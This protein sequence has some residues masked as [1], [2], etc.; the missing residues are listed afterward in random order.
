MKFA[1]AVNQQGFAKV[2][3]FGEAGSGKTFTAHAI[4]RGLHGYIKSTK[5]VVCVETESGVDF[6]LPLYKEAGIEIQVAKTRAFADLMGKNGLM[7]EAQKSADIMVIDSITHH[8]KDIVESYRIKN[9][10]TR[11]SFGDWNIIKPMWSVFVDLYL[12]SNLHIIECGRSGFEYDYF[13]NEDGKMELYKTGTKMKVEKEMAY[14]PSLMIEMERFKSFQVRKTKKGKGQAQS[15]IPI[16]SGWVHRAHILKD[17]AQKL[18]GMEFDDPTFESFLPHFLALNLGG[19]HLGVE[20]SRTSEGMFEREGK[21]NWKWEAEQKDILIAEFFASLDKVYP[22]PTTPAQKRARIMVGEECFGVK[23]R[24]SIDAL[25]YQQIKQGGEKAAWYLGQEWLI[26][27]L[28][29]EAE[30]ASALSQAREA[31]KDMLSRP[32]E[33]KPIAP[34]IEM[35]VS[36]RIAAMKEIDPELYLSVCH[37]LGIQPMSLDGVEKVEA[38]FNKELDK[39]AKG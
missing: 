38:E 3:I 7:E 21:P 27:S 17:R 9:G 13:E 35:N 11:L 29:D 30:S 18:D 15:T 12:N 39:K 1:A 2:G 37:R 19:E 5:P 22:S 36:D 28:L 33:K 32:E 14:E 6:M 10:L 20:T 24:E 34:V 23:S 4:A 26:K 31:W 25:K 8:W 16:G